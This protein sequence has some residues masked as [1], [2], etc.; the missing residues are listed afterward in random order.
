MLRPVE[1]LLKAVSQFESIEPGS[2]DAR[3]IERRTDLGGADERRVVLRIERIRDVSAQLEAGHRE[4]DPGIDHTVGGLGVVVVTSHCSSVISK[5]LAPHTSS[6][7]HPRPGKRKWEQQS[8][9][10]TAE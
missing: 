4:S 6:T 1:E 2:P 7:L 5:P 9:V 3:H 8:A 10:H